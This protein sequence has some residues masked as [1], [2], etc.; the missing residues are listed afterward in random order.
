MRNDRAEQTADHVRNA[1][2]ANALEISNQ[3]KVQGKVVFQH[4]ATTITINLDSPRVNNA[5]FHYVSRMT[6]EHVAIDKTAQKIMDAIL[7][8]PAEKIV[9]LYKAASPLSY[10]YNAVI[11]TGGWGYE[12]VV[13]A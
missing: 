4:G 1:I 5:E 9:A 13:F 8:L 6:G 12:P 2:P 7:A 10:G 3:R 11:S